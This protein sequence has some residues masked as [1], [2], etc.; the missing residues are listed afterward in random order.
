MKKNGCRNVGGKQLTVGILSLQGAVNEH[1]NCLNK[2]K[3]KPVVVKK[4]NQ[5]DQL[6]GLIIPG[7]ES[8]TIGKL[9]IEYN[10][11]EKIKNRVNQGMGIFGTCAGLILLAN[12][13]SKS[14]KTH[15]GLININVK[16]NAFGRQVN[17][18][19]TELEITELGSKPFPGVF[20]RAPEII[21]T[22]SSVQTM[23]QYNNKKVLAR[24]NR[25]LVASFHPELTNDLR[26]HRYFLSLLKY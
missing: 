23:A 26:L 20:I 6:D 3:C 15:L 4:K 21:E 12:N 25:I 17:S 13:I 18:F 22:G 8:T 10:Y 1:L 2:I 7:G 16:R 11:V 5:L 24:Q 9:L 19:E 14:T